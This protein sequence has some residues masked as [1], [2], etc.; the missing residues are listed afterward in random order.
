VE[1]LGVDWLS[2]RVCGVLFMVSWCVRVGVQQACIRLCSFVNQESFECHVSEYLDFTREWVH[3]MEPTN[4]SKLTLLNFDADIIYGCHVL[5]YYRRAVLR[6]TIG[7]S[8]TQQ[9]R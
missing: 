3:A 7:S 5:C 8:D 6:T 2:V 1:V 4:Y 9:R